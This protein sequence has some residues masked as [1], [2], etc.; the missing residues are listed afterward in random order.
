MPNR[1]V[2]PTVS[3]RTIGLL[4]HPRLAAAQELA[5]R[6]RAGLLGRVPEVWTAAAW[7]EPGASQLRHTD[8]LVCIGGD[9]TMLRAARLALPLALPLIGVNMGRLG[10][11]SELSPED[12]LP[13]LHHV[14]E[15]AGRIEERV[16]L[17]AEI[18]QPGGLPAPD[19]DRQLALNDVAV[20]RFGGRPV[21]LDVLL[22]GTQ[23]EVV[24]ADSMV[25]S[26]ATGSTGYNL[27]AG[28]PVLFPESDDLV[29]TPVAAH[30][31][32]VRPLVLPRTTR[33]E[34]RVHS[35][36]PAI[37]SFDGQID[38]AMPEGGSVVVTCHQSRA[39]FIRLG[40]P[41]EFFRNLTTLLDAGRRF[42]R[43]R[44]PQLQHEA[45]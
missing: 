36:V 40:P 31:S 33:I 9:G 23:V 2:C 14:L 5:G 39:R 28:G 41:S 18:Q 37:A 38:Y 30:L 32:R 16:M 24:R 1:G 11:L 15:G 19:I 43:D 6:L 4:Y 44:R 13:R 42:E 22:D 21:D 20:G 29:L 26:T 27:S 8:L 45:P 3:Y 25:V 7:E 10:F 12:A 17:S 35:D 34:L